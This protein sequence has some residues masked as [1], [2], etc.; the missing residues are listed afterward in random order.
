MPFRKRNGE[1]YFEGIEVL[2]RNHLPKEI[3]A[4]Y[5]ALCP[6]CAAK[7]REFV[8]NDDDAMAK[9]KVAII[10]MDNDEIEI[11]LGDERAS[12][13]FTQTHI[14]DLKYIVNQIGNG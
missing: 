6:L 9:L 5:L 12:I 3:E 2:S 13:R 1:Y 14:H 7:Y 4:Q 8:I 11:S 10:G